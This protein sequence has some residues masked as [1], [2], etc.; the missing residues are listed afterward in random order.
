M[1]GTAAFID[2]WQWLILLAALPFFLFPNPSSSPILALVP[3]LW[4]IALAGRRNPLPATPLNGEMLLVSIMMLVSLFATYDV[5]VS[6]P[7]ISGVLIGIA[8]FYL[9]V[10]IGSRSGGWWMCFLAFL[11]VGSG[12]TVV[13][14]VGTNW[15]TDKFAIIAKIISVLP[16]LRQSLPGAPDGFHPNE[17]GGALVWVMPAAIIFGLVW[18]LRFRTLKKRIGAG[19]I[20]LILCAALG[21]SAIMG[22]VLVFSQSRSAF[23]GLGLALMAALFF[24]LPLPGR[25]AYGI[26]MVMGISFVIVLFWPINASKLS[27]LLGS[28]EVQASAFSLSTL[29]LRFEIWS[30]A[31]YGIQDFP[32]TG[33]GMNTFR[34]VVN[35]LYP[36]FSVGPN[37]DIGHAH[38]EFLQAALDL[39]IPGLIAFIGIYIGA[40][41]MLIDS[42]RRSGKPGENMRTVDQPAVI[43]TNTLILGLGSGLAA[44][45]IYGL[46]DAV[47]LGAKPGLLYWML[48]GLI[49]GL[50]YHVRRNGFVRWPFSNR[51]A[52]ASKS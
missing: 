10:R 4:L 17:V 12:M 2:H 16:K 1:Q 49:V 15:V 13:S 6:L 8:V 44:H 25:W 28:S 31:I 51:R 30:R 27:G 5:S 39:G 35:V 33:M 46:T 36:L 29:D 32:L 38:N 14:L 21:I 22:V 48:L 47:A 24:A 37:Y 19:W 41:W 7:K 11:L 45:L 3:L 42:W 23:I 9:M 50:F 52:T 43:L 40:F 34:T 26:V 18:M 20:F